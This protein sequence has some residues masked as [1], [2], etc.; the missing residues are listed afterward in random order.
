[1]VNTRLSVAIHILSLIAA[2]PRESSEMIAGS[3][4]TNPVVIRRMISQLKKGGILTSRPGVA[5]ATLKRDPEDISLLDIY[6][7]V[8]PQEELFAIHDKPNPNCPVGRQIQTTL[9]Q[10]FH[11]VQQAMENELASKSLKDV[12]THLF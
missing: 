3:V 8:Q 7:A 6:R 4:N 2:N 1:M 9:D 12:L 11:S 5:G 10:T